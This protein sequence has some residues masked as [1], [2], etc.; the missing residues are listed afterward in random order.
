MFIKNFNQFVWIAKFL[1][2]MSNEA[3]VSGEFLKKVKQSGHEKPTSSLNPDH[4]TPKID[5]TAK[6]EIPLTSGPKLKKVYSESFEVEDFKAVFEIYFFDQNNQ[7]YLSQQV[8]LYK[9][10]EIITRCASY[11]GL[12]QRYLV[13]GSCAGNQEG[14]LYGIALYKQMVAYMK[15]NFSRKLK[16]IKTPILSA[17]D[18]A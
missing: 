14:K 4:L 12:D 11:F 7:K 16:D 8:F 17:P 2:K 13:P 6:F 15:Q 10:G 18:V 1:N 3:E 5:L 9:G